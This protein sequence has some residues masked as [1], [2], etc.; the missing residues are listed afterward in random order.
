M[1]TMHSIDVGFV[2]TCLAKHK[3]YID[4][5]RK[6]L[7]N[8]VQPSVWFSVRGNLHRS[9]VVFHHSLY[10][11]CAPAAGLFCA[12]LEPVCCCEGLP[13]RFPEAPRSGVYAFMM[14]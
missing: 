9:H 4:S 5:P 10:R 3:K 14:L 12:T 11:R 7:R 2:L 6:M 8:A 1:L 13:E